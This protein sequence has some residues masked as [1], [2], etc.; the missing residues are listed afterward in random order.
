[1][2]VH[3][4]LADIVD[5][6]STNRQEHEAMR[7]E[8]VTKQDLAAESAAIRA[9]MKSEFGTVDNR[10]R[11]LGLEFEAFRH[12]TK[13]TLDMLSELMARTG[14]HEKSIAL[15]DRRLGRVEHHLKI[16]PLPNAG[17]Q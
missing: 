10:L 6:L 7:A 9:E 2:T 15:L 14:R 4:V 11:Q 3:K 13:I 12:E 8:M 16:K 17:D 1:M 5:A